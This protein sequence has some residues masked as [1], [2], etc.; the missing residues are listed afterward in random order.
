MINKDMQKKM[1][2]QRNTKN[3]PTL[4]PTQKVDKP[5]LGMIDNTLWI[6]ANENPTENE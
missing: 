6:L 1:T 5:I 4:Q 2:R 3:V